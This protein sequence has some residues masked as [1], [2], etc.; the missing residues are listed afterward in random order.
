MAKQRLVLLSPDGIPIHPTASYANKK[1]AFTAFNKWSKRF[2][3]QGY[4]SSNM[5]RIHVEDLPESC[6]L[7]KEKDKYK[8]VTNYHLAISASLWDQLAKWLH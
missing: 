5:G 8:M 7:V 6:S 2:K 4:Y 1:E 3:K